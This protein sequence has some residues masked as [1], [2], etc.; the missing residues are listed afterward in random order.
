MTIRYVMCFHCSLPQKKKNLAEKTQTGS[1]KQPI[2]PEGRLW[3]GS[4]GLIVEFSAYLAAMLPCFS[5]VIPCY[6]KMAKRRKYGKLNVTEKFLGLSQSSHIIP[7][8][9]WDDPILWPPKNGQTLP[10]RDAN[11]LVHLGPMLQV[12]QI[13]GTLPRVHSRR[14]GG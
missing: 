12:L 8:C 2:S 3:R 5:H 13:A 10:R 9:D 6:P 14:V 7:C 1:P 4:P 11:I